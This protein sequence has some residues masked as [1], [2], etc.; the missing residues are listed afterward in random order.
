M[1]QN[2][3]GLMVMRIISAILC[4]L[5]C[6]GVSAA[7]PA[8][9]LADLDWLWGEWQVKTKDQSTTESWRKISEN[10]AEG[11]GQVHSAEGKLQS[12]EALRIVSMQNELFLLAKVTSNQLPVA[13]KLSF[14]QPQQAIFEN[15]SHD[16]PTHLNYRRHQNKLLVTVTGSDGKGFHLN[17][18]SIN[19]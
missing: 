4:I 13:F 11:I 15:N 3:L 6:F 5:I 18:Q 8:C 12:Q 17:Y 7:R 1:I 2:E 19:H 14:C 10:T 9:T 16:F